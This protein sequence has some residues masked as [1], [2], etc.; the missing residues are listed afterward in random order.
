MDEPMGG[1]LSGRMSE[2]GGVPRG[3]TRGARDG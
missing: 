1:V 2:R 3:L